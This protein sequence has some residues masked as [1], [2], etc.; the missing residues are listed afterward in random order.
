MT[1]PTM[2]RRKITNTSV[3]LIEPGFGAAVTGD[4]DQSALDDVLPAAA[5]A[6]PYSRPSIIDVTLGMRTAVQVGR[7]VPVGD[8]PGRSARC[9]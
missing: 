5:V 2:G 7:N 9:L 4:L 6:F 8:R 3:E 1:E